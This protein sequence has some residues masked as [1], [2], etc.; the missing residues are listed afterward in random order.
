M[1][2]SRILKIQILFK[3]KKQKTEQ[4]LNHMVLFSD[5]QLLPKLKAET[6]I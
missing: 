2:I 5:L 1:K 3:N 6:A 4:F